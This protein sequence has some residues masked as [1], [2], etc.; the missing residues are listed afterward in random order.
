[1][2]PPSAE[3]GL[4]RGGGLWGCPPPPPSP[5]YHFG[6]DVFEVLVFALHRLQQVGLDRGGVWGEGPL[7]PPRLWG[8]VVARH[9]PTDPPPFYGHGGHRELLCPH[10]PTLEKSPM[11]SRWSLANMFSISSWQKDRERSSRAFC[12]QKPPRGSAAPLGGC[13]PPQH[14]TRNSAAP[15][16]PD[17]PPAAQQPPPPQHLTH[18]SAAPPKPH[19][20]LSTTP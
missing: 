20:W 15:P 6:G 19:P 13:S 12:G 4:K 17:T 7:P 14:P 16:T 11:S 9:G 8:R 10:I 5:R 18:G 2:G 3:T 1:M